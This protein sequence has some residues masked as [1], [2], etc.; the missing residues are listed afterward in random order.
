MKKQKFLLIFM[1]LSIFMSVSSQDLKLT[2]VNLPSPS[3]LF[4]FK[5]FKTLGERHIFYGKN[6][7]KPNGKVILFV[8][9]YLEEADFLLLGNCF[10][11]YAYKEGYQT[12]FVSMT[13]GQG[14]WVNGEILQ[15]AIE[16]VKA[17]YNVNSIDIVAHSNGG[18]ASEVAL[19]H[20][21]K[22]W[23]VNKII[24]L[25]TPFRGTQ[26]A[27]VFDSSISS[28]VLQILGLDTG[29]AYSSTFYC[30]TQWRPYFDGI[31]TPAQRRKYYNYGAW[32]YLHGKELLY[33][34]IMA[35][36]GA[37]IKLNGGG[38]NDGVTPFYS[39][40]IPGGNQ[41]Y[42]DRAIQGKMNHMDMIYGQHT[43][44][45]INLVLSMNFTPYVDTR[46]VQA[47]II[48]DETE[49]ARS[50]NYQ[51]LSDSDNN[52]EGDLLK[53]PEATEFKITLIKENENSDF[54]LVN[55][56][57][58]EQMHLADHS[59]NLLRSTAS[60]DRNK[61]IEEITV[62]FAS[63]KLRST[64][65]RQS[66]QFSIVGDS[67]FMAIVEQNI[68]CP[69]NYK[70]KNTSDET[71]LEVTFP[72]LNKDLL[73]KVVVKGRIH[74]LGSLD[75]I[76]AQ[77]NEKQEVEF[78][79]NGDHFTYNASNLPDG[80]YSISITGSLEGVY[81]RDIVSGFT[82]GKLAI[83][84]KTATDQSPILST[85]ETSTLNIYPN[86]TTDVLNITME[87]PADYVIS[88]LQGRNIASGTLQ[89][90]VNNID[91]IG[92]PKGVYLITVNDKS[93]I[94]SQKIVIK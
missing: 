93:S 43:W 54:T 68:D 37:I 27:D 82:V 47:P 21:G 92:L 65:D 30:D 91:V 12:A 19:F 62:S 11:K 39:S 8:P 46:S 61:N 55:T 73:N 29:R 22:I 26:I 34:G 32:G 20:Y 41:L 4:S 64:S 31:A 3:S 35:A 33:S 72:K 24:T 81:K 87:N 74:Y 67:R 17:H 76:L 71:I 56:V 90:G 1:A 52:Y 83:Q 9:G 6:P 13:R 85:D 66:E 63:P 14:D 86:P 60:E 15:R 94:Q 51:V 89:V 16:Q 18:K 57:T 28:W 40:I 44:K 42:S 2:E 50:S 36:S 45:Y 69:L 77:D 38:D 75:G 5:Y 58:G 88:D 10:Y 70:F 80:V 59:A 79:F 48:S 84:P 49:Y 78:S 23:S 7:K 53:D 25:G